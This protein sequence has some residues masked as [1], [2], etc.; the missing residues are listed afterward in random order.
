MPENVQ[1]WKL[2]YNQ[3]RNHHICVLR[4]AVFVNAA[5]LAAAATQASQLRMLQTT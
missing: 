3:H 4:F 2:P 1:A 5:K